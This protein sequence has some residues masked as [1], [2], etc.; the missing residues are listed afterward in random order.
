MV[1]QN[2]SL[3]VAQGLG[4]ILS[5]FRSEYD[6]AKT[7][8]VRNVL[9]FASAAWSKGTAHLMKVGHMFDIYTSRFVG[10]SSQIIGD[11]HSK[12]HTNLE[13]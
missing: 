6:A 8:V 10:V 4:D 1:G 5:L 12:R 3:S 11:L 13:W 7:I 2:C 9:Q